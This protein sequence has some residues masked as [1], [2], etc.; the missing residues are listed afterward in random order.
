VSLTNRKRKNTPALAHF[1]DLANPRKLSKSKSSISS[2][3][4]VVEVAEQ[5]AQ[6][7]H[8]EAE[9]LGVIA[10]QSRAKTLAAAR[11][12]R[13]KSN[14]ILPKASRSPSVAVGLVE[15]PPTEALT[16]LAPPLLSPQQVG[17]VA[18][19]H[20][21]ANQLKQE[22]LVVVEAP[23]QAQQGHQVQRIKVSL[24]A[25]AELMESQAEAVE[26][27]QLE[28]TETLER[29]EKAETVA[30]GSHH[31]SQAQAQQEL[32][33]AA[34]VKARSLLPSAQAELAAEAMAA[35]LEWQE[36]STQVAA[37][38]E[39]EMAESVVTVARAWSSS[40]TT[41]PIPN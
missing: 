41:R 20:L 10:P 16:E 17:E 30:Q 3:L 31:P 5:V 26:L 2:S 8:Q 37:E 9:D 19:V 12:P 18:Q 25:T 24:E 6:A 29:R 40:D 35:A 4:A 39:V 33:A 28:S 14:G 38:V 13:L 34:A 7:T 32:A 21:A 23:L 36:Q 22:A 1:S 11:L 27:R 15:H